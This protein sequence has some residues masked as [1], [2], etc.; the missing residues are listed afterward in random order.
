MAVSQGVKLTVVA[1]APAAVVAVVIVVGEPACTQQ[2]GAQSAACKNL[3][4]YMGSFFLNRF[5]HVV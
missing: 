3:L 1:R 5:L 4:K 2:R